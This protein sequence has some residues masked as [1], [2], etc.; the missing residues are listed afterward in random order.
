MKFFVTYC[1]VF[2]T[3]VCN[4]QLL[5]WSP[6]FIS[7]TSSSVEISMNA[8]Y[9]NKALKDYTN[10]TDVYV[11]IGAITNLSSS[12]SDW[13]YV[14]FTWGTTASAA[15]CS[16]VGSNV[17]KYSISTD[18]RTF[19]G[20]TNSSE[21]IL[22]IAIL[23]RNGSGNLVQRNIDA[24]DMYVPVYDN[25]L[26]A[27]IDNPFKQ[28]TYSP[29]P[30]PLTVSVG[31]NLS[32]N[33]KSN[34]PADLKLYFNGTQISNLNN[35]NEIATN[36]TI[37]SGGQQTIVVEATASSVTKYDTLKFF[38]NVTP[39]I[40]ALPSGVKDGINYE[41]GDTSVTLVLFAPNK[42][43]VSL[44]GDFNNWTQTI[45][46]QLNKTPD[47]N[48][49]WIRL[50]GLTPSTEYAYQYIIDGSIKVA[51]YYTEKVLDPWN[52]SYIPS[53]T[54]PSLKPYPTGLTTGIVSIIQTAKPTYNWQVSSLI[55]LTKAT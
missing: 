14:K 43:N 16:F 35:A 50:T 37:V 41:P 15:Q 4:A 13:K 9:G 19:F 46:H 1:F 18:L 42:S 51:D 32:I 49:F 45:Q 23:F 3:L 20:I 10:T 38:I 17:W 55:N 33:A 34:Q 39:N 8:T 21:K 25:T 28:P 53:T 2:F 29:I 12:S 44:I 48:R 5:S 26:S 27:R 30:E 24:S 11:H 47:G 22:K 40:A 31:N 36:T 6:N 54:Y 52:D 7:E